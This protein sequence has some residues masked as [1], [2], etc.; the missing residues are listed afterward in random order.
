M[1]IMI[2]VHSRRLKGIASS[3]RSHLVWRIKFE[4]ALNDLR[5][6]VYKIYNNSIHF[7]S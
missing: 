4:G 1:L 6:V 2:G 3:A 5:N 7:E